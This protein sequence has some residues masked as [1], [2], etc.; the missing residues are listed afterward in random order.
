MTD[1]ATLVVIK[2]DAIKR[3]LAGRVLSRLEELRLEIIGAKVVRVGR[4]LAE[5]HYKALR[6]RPFFE[7]LLEL[8]QG[9]LHDTRY[10]LALV[11]WGPEAIARV[12][13]ATGSTHPEKADPLSLRGSLGRMTTTG[14]MENILHASADAI[15]A[16]REIKLWFTP[17]EL[18]H[19][20][21]G[22][23]HW[24]SGVRRTVQR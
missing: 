8:I 12:R 6:E 16:E 18:L 4:E 2:P 21:F 22:S 20:P 17:Q 10:V 15:D 19:N 3:G 5:E 24:E 1:E 7:E 14:V 13:Q 11:F 23:Q 9:N